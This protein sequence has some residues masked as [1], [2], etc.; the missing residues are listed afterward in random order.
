MLTY[1]HLESICIKPYIA[2]ASII[3]EGIFPN[4]LATVNIPSETLENA[5]P[6][7]ITP[8][9]VNGRILKHKITQN[10]LY[11]SSCFNFKITGWWVSVCLHFFNPFRYKIKLMNAPNPSPIIE[12]IKPL[13]RPKIVRFPAVINTLGHIPIMLTNILMNKLKKT[14][15]RPACSNN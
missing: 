15:N 4:V 1:F 14:A 2:P 6:N 12:T 8:E 5:L 3:S 10:A 11:P 7:V 13:Y 9:G